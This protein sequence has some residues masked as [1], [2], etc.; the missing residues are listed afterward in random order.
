MCSGQHKFD[1][2]SSACK[3]ERESKAF[4]LSHANSV[5]KLVFYTTHAS[6]EISTKWTVMAAGVYRTL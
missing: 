4:Y 6:S 3:C 2:L 1:Y 5:S